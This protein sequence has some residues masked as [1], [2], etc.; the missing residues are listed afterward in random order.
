MLIEILLYV[1]AVTITVSQSSNP[2]FFH[3]I[4]L[5]CWL[6]QHDIASTIERIVWLS[7]YRDKN[8]TT[9]ASAVA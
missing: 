9:W 1:L 7:K 4:D 6:C 8:I 5:N 3:D 2:T